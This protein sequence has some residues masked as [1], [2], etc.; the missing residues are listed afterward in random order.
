MEERISCWFSTVPNPALRH[1]CV[2]P[3]DLC[4]VP[5]LFLPFAP[6][7][8][9]DMTENIH[10]FFTAVNRQQARPSANRAQQE[11]P[12]KGPVKRKAKSLTNSAPKK[13]PQYVQRGDKPPSSLTLEA[14]SAGWPWLRCDAVIGLHCARMLDMVEGLGIVWYWV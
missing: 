6:P 10:Q 1:S 9:A 2:V 3:Q 14:W 12:K 4:V 5:T 11:P 7:L 8:F 13:P